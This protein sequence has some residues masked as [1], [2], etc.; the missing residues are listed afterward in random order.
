MPNANSGRWPSSVYSL[1]DEPDPRFSLANE[2]T[3]LAW[4]RTASSVIAGGLALAVYASGNSGHAWIS[5]VA[6]GAFFA[7]AGLGMA[8]FA[9]WMH[10]ERAL[11][12]KQPMPAP[13]F[14]LFGLLVVV[15]LLVVIG[16][17]AIGAFNG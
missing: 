8:A 14:L 5:V 9:R 16:G 10:V 1:G 7:G 4:I 12:L 3:A 15:P 13:T 11:R 2:R 6:V 17:L